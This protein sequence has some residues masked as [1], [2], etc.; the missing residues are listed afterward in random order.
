MKIGQE[1][2]SK[3][4]ASPDGIGG[5]VRIWRNS[6][7][8]ATSTLVRAIVFLPS[9]SVIAPSAFTLAVALQMF[10]WN[11]LATSLLSARMISSLPSAP[12]TLMAIWQAEA[13]ARS[14]LAH[15]ASPLIFLSSAC[16][17]RLSARR[18]EEVR[19]AIF[20]MCEV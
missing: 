2:Q 15:T 19:I 3:K 20:F 17:E 1:P 14:H 12:F 11:A 6:A 4:N 18:S 5:G 9:F 16:R 10:L 8:F 7:Y 13:V